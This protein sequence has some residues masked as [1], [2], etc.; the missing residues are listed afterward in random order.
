MAV[1]GPNGHR[2]PDRFIFDSFPG[3]GQALAPRLL[4]AFGADR[5]QLSVRRTN[6]DVVGNRSGN[7]VEWEE[8]ASS[9]PAWPTRSFLRQSFHEFVRAIQRS[10]DLFEREFAVR[11]ERQKKARAR[12]AA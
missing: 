7:R 10:P 11:E 6:S 2:R 8:S 9:L 3:A 12:A 4:A 5:D 1:Y